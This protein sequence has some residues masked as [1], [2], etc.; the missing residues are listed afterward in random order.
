MGS[1]RSQ[2]IGICIEPHVPAKTGLVSG[3]PRLTRSDQITAR[4]DQDFSIRAV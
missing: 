4:G 2:T 3:I 1:R